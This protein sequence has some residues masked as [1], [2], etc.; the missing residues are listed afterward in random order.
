VSTLVAPP[1]AFS[2]GGYPPPA[3]QGFGG[4]PA[5]SPSEPTRKSA[6]GRII[7]RVG[8]A[9]VAG[10]IG[11]A[12]KDA[13]FGDKAKDAAAGDCVASSKD[14]KAKGQTDAEA[15]VVDCGSADAAFTVMGRVDG[16]TDTNSKSCDR[17]FKEGEEFYVYSSTTAGGY[18][19]CLKPKS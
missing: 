17:Y 10:I 15:K 4:F 8:L 6:V 18:L 19:L 12:V 16:E 5:A 14:V 7:L 1:P 11:L 2:E 3:D 13:L 9:L